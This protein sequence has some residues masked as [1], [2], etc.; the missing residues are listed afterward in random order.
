M[1][2][3]SNNNLE[4]IEPI[5]DVILQGSFFDSDHVA[6]LLAS[7]SDVTRLNGLL[8]AQSRKSSYSRKDLSGL[9]EVLTAMEKAFPEAPI[10]EIKSGFGNKKVKMIWQCVNGHAASE[11]ESFCPKCIRDRRGLKG[12]EFDKAKSKLEQRLLALNQIFHVTVSSGVDAVESSLTV[13]K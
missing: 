1:E 10:E 5:R 3:F 13:T 12:G 8:F 11:S 9:T 7:E 2:Y 4:P 6:S